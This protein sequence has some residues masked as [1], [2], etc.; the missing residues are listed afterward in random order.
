MPLRALNGTPPPPSHH[1]R[2]PGTSFLRSL[3][4][5]DGTVYSAA[6]LFVFVHCG[7]RD[8]IREAA[9]YQGL[10]P[11]LRLRETIGTSAGSVA[12]LCDVL[13]LSGSVMFECLRRV[14]EEESETLHLNPMR[15]F[16]TLGMISPAI[17]E[18]LALMLLRQRVGDQASTLTLGGMHDMT[19]IRFVAVAYNVSQE[20]VAY[21][22]HETYPDLPVWKAICMSC[23]IPGLVEP[24][25]WGGSMYVDGGV[26]EALPVGAVRLSACP[27][28]IS[29]QPCRAGP[30]PGQMS[31]PEL[32]LRVFHAMNRGPTDALAA[33]PFAQR[34]YTALI[35]LP[36]TPDYSMI[37]GLVVPPALAARLAS[38][39]RE[40]MCKLLCPS[41]WLL[42]ALAARRALVRRDCAGAMGYKPA[43]AAAAERVDARFEGVRPSRRRSV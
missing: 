3:A 8:V 32:A 12:A 7:A 13:G 43:A 41:G 15:M 27:L 23:C 18:A 36:S 37:Q 25:V 10:G 9:A 17:L 21:L 22:S 26:C 6:G 11:R 16:S 31:M 5:V 42:M 29:L 4:Q 20:Q 19:G 34:P 24:I 28:V 1:D 38:Y 39:G 35:S 33:A 2:Q 14:S 30:P 40:A